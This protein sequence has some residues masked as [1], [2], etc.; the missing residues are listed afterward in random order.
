MSCFECVA[1]MMDMPDPHKQ[2]PFELIAWAQ[3]GRVTA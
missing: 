1:E 2:G 3:N